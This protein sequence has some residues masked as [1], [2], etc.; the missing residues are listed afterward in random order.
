MFIFLHRQSKTPD[1]CLKVQHAHAHPST[2]RFGRA[3]STQLST[4][5]SSQVLSAHMCTC[6]HP[7]TWPLLTT[8]LDAT[9]LLRCVTSVRKSLTRIRVTLSPRSLEANRRLWDYFPLGGLIDLDRWK[10]S[11]KEC[12]YLV[13]SPRTSLQ[14]CTSRHDHGW[15]AIK[16]GRRRL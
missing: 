1:C 4:F 2:T 10:E 9:S 7:H 6:T 5:Q 12:A 11:S 3:S 13:A 8:E 14:S 16:Q 15:G